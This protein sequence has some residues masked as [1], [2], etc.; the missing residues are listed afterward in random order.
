[1]DGTIFDFASV[2]KNA[3]VKLTFDAGQNRKEVFVRQKIKKSIKIVL[4]KILMSMLE[5]FALRMYLHTNDAKKCNF[6]CL[7]YVLYLNNDQISFQKQHVGN[8]VRDL[9]N[10]VKQ[11]KNKVCNSDVGSVPADVSTFQKLVIYLL[12]CSHENRTIFILCKSQRYFFL[13]LQ[14]S[15][16]LTFSRVSA[17]YFSPT[18]SLQNKEI[19]QL[20]PLL[21]AINSQQTRSKSFTS[22]LP[23]IDSQQDWFNFFPK[24]RVPQRVMEKIG[25][26]SSENKVQLRPVHASLQ[27]DLLS[28]VFKGKK[29]SVEAG[30]LAFC[31]YTLEKLQEK[32]QPSTL[33]M[34]TDVVNDILNDVQTG[35]VDRKINK[36][37]NHVTVT[38]RKKLDEQLEVLKPIFPEVI[39]QA[40]KN[41]QLDNEKASK[42][43]KDDVKVD[44]ILKTETDKKQGFLLSAKWS[45]AHSF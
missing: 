5:N 20:I 32:E 39:N 29:Y 6:C 22:S 2:L 21:Q 33:E 45:F 15:N 11:T 35:K 25:L 28:K 40:A 30:S 24:Y 14:P 7:D 44:V 34:Y 23:Y 37:W 26:A 12:S 43:L 41:F 10:N 38:Q 17:S 3:K 1:M 31:A 18:G 42:L 4:K 27:N 36:L 8:I 19:G 13:L 9:E 16:F